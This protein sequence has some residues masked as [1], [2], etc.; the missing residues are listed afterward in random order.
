MFCPRPTST[1]TIAGIRV[2]LGAAYTHRA[3]ARA[4]AIIAN[5]V[6]SCFIYT[7]ANLSSA[8]AIWRI[9]PFNL[10]TALLVVAAG[11]LS[12]DWNWLLWVAAVAVLATAPFFGKI[13]GFAVQP[14]HFVERHSL[15]LIIAFGESI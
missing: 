14:A 12:P 15:V 3:A 9:A 11:L 5:A 8:R 7:C 2:L 13:G 1:V 4:N 6:R 10:G